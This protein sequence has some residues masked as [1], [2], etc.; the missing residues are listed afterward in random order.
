MLKPGML[1]RANLEIG[2]GQPV[3]MAPKD[4]LVLNQ[5]KASLYLIDRRDGKVIARQ[6]AVQTGNPSGN[7]IEI[8]GDV[9]ENVE[10]VVQGNERLRD[11]EEV[12]VLK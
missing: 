7:W 8:I 2:R 5:G 1:A 4:A 9:A 12:K 11:G 3:L 6:T 10:V